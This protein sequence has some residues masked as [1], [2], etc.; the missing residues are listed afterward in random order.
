M[1]LVISSC[2]SFYW[3]LG[4]GPN[5]STTWNICGVIMKESKFR[6]WL[7]NIWIDN[8]KEHEDYKELPYSMDEYWARYK[9]WLKREYR[10]QEGN[11]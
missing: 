8:C 7:R 1:V 5:C 6:N 10:H 9:Y 3:A 11:K 2:I 4:A